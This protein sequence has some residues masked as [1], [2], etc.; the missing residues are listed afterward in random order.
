MRLIAIA[1]AA[2]M[3]LSAA[4]A[5][6]D[7]DLQITEIWPGNSLGEDDLTSDWFEVTNLGDMAYDATIDGDLYFDDDSMGLKDGLLDNELTDLISG[8]TA[9]APGESVIFIDDEDTS[10]FVAAWGN[11]AILPQLGTYSGSGLS[12]GGDGVTLFLSTGLPTG[13]GNIIDFELYP[14]ASLSGGA[15]FDVMLQA[16]SSIGNAS[17]ALETIAVNDASQ[18]AIASVGPAVPEPAAAILAG[19]AACGLLAAR[20]R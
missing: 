19:L 15:S 13:I 11:V 12:G 17:G 10:E 5:N 6:A 16:F 1:A 4:T 2:T 14:D 7:F 20:R 3:A 8:V 9:I 18:T